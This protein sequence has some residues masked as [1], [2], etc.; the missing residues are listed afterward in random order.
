M[1]AKAK[2]SKA[3]SKPSRPAK[4]KVRPLTRQG[5]EEVVQ[6]IRPAETWAY[7]RN[8]HKGCATFQRFNGDP[9]YPTDRDWTD[10]IAPLT[11]PP[12]GGKLANRNYPDTTIAYLRW[13]WRV[14]E[15]KPARYRWSI[16]TGALKAAKD[17]QLA[18]KLAA[19][20]VPLDAGGVDR[21]MRPILEAAST[22]GFSAI[23]NI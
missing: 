22:G 6:R 1:A 21:Y 10:E 5:E 3:K 8:P 13:V 20:P 9:L 15:P 11:F 16:V 17:P 7:L 18:M 12:F 14:I 4:R 2:G 23:Q 19:M